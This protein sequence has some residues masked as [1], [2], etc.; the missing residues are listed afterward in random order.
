MELD[1]CYHT[2]TS[3]CGHASGLDEEYVLK[4]IEY[5]I[6]RLG[7]SDHV[8]LPEG[9][10]QPG[11]RGNPE[12]IDDYFN[13]INYLKEKY[14]DQIEIHLGF[15]AEYYPQMMDYYK[16]LLDSGKIEYF[17][18]GQHFFMKEDGEMVR[19]LY[20]D[21]GIDRA[22]MYTEDIIKG[23]ESGLFSY[24][25]HPDLFIGA[26]DEW[27]KELEDCARRIL[28]AVEKA[29]I[30]LEVNI[31]GMRGQYSY[32]KG[33]KYPDGVFFDL[34]NQYDIDVVIGV[35]A[36]SPDDFNHHDIEKALDFAERHHLRLINFML[37]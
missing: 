15:E 21:C 34:V 6:K 8:I 18:L 37:K 22:Y 17:I 1:Y 36:H 32:Y 33:L 5:G 23:I 26:Y 28:K 11:I 9:Y 12:Q 19:Y 14:K 4:A 29:K 2:H 20:K 10:R 13:S 3:R 35:D 16:S 25:A 7:F 27:N 30:P 24:V 31:G